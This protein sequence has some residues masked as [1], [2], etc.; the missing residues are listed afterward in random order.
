MRGQGHQQLCMLWDL[1][2]LPN[3]IFMTLQEELREIA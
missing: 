3:G 1:I 2:Y